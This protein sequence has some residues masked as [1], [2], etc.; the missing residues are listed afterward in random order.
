MTQ[1][2]KETHSAAAHNDS[3]MLT[4]DGKKE[5]KTALNLEASFEYLDL[6]LDM[7]YTTAW[8]LT[9][10]WAHHIFM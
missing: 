3:R 10:Q 9:A 4:L 8:L 7:I 5:G 6:E 2:K 1:T